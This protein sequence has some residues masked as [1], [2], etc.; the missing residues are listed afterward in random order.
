M[1][2]RT[3]EPDY[4]RRPPGGSNQ[5]RLADLERQLHRLWQLTQQI[6][7]SENE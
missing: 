7:D 4:R 5:S 2:R 6:G 1:P 3:Y